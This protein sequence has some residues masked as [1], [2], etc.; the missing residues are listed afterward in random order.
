MNPLFN[1]LWQSTVFAA[2]AGLLA[3]A[4]RTNSAQ[5]RYRVWL[6]AS[7]KFLIPFS[8]LIAMGS[9]L[10]W[11]TSASV[12]Q[13]A[14]TA[15][16][17]Q[18]QQSL[19]VARD[20]SF[21]S[22][23]VVPKASSPIVGI[24]LAVWIC[25]VFATLASWGRRWLRVRA[26]VRSA[27]PLILD[28]PI[29]ALSS[30]SLLEPGVF[31]VFR[32]VLLLPAGI[33]GTL[34]REHLEAILAHELCHVRRRD[35]LAA[36]IHMVIEALFWF[37]PLV[38][39]IGARLV[40]ER[41]RACD[42]EV[43]RLGNRPRIY[44]ESILKTCQFY[45]ESPLACVSGVTGADLK[46]R[47]SRI[48]AG[49]RVAR[50]NIHKKLLLTCAGLT[51]VVLP[52]ALGL[53]NGLLMRAQTSAASAAPTASFEVA[54][55]KPTKP[56]APG[57]LMRIDAGSRFN[58][59]G[60]SVMLLLEQ[61][62]GVRE[63][64]ISQAPPWLTSEHFDIDAKAEDSAAAAIDKLPPEERKE[65]LQQMLQNLLAERFKLELG[66][67]TKELPV[68]A[69]VVAKN[70]PKLQVSSFKPSDGPPPK[71]EPIKG[72]AP[73]P[74]S[75]FM[76]APGRIVSTGAQIAMLADILSRFAGR[77]VVDKTGLAGC[78]DF[79]LQWHDEGHGPMSFGGPGGPGGPVGPG[80]PG[81]GP[82]QEA[83]GPSLFTALQEQLGLKLEPQK[84]PM[85]VLV[86]KHVEKP[87]EN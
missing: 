36:A 50:L 32:P 4:L 78:Y 25:G 30:P 7:L 79:T 84:A 41:E 70:G 44:A 69:L 12:A 42:E 83:S 27:Q 67:D 39:W 49:H 86:I 17:T 68:Y 9:H 37:H 62:Y 1:H 26:I 14:F 47:V 59:N 72:G 24:L 65:K 19:V 31:G 28:A 20:F 40:E 71:D 10:H 2:A 87:S 38:W 3:L 8:L 11:P 58:A 56:G 5:V 64:Q 60:I 33:T 45:L 48:M 85:D 82:P 77:V 43:L 51:A 80:G 76:N 55:I 34:T 29:P 73:G 63:A 61:A 52:L 66:H 54:S 18:I 16:A 74:G 53:T 21:L 46:Q 23:P 6:I 35:N 13:P 22:R 15:A 75:M 81:G 57:T